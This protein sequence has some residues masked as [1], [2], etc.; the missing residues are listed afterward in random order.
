MLQVISLVFQ[1]VEG[2]ILDLPAGLSPPHDVPDVLRN[3]EKVGDPTEMLNP[4]IGVD[5][6]VFQHIDQFV[7]VRLVERHA[8]TEPKMMHNARRWI[9]QGKDLHLAGLTDRRPGWARLPW[10]ALWKP[11]AQVVPVM[12]FSSVQRSRRAWWGTNGW[13]A[14][15]SGKPAEVALDLAH[16]NPGTVGP[17]HEAESQG[18]NR[19]LQEE[20]FHG[21]V[22]LAD[23][24]PLLAGSAVKFQGPGAACHEHQFAHADLGVKAEL[25]SRAIIRA[26]DLDGEIGP[27]EPVGFAVLRRVARQE[28]R[29]VRAA[30]VTFPALRSTAHVA[31]REDLYVLPRAESGVDCAG[32]G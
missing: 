17:R 11:R 29:H 32:K 31:A 6:P 21:G 26:L 28:D 27:A 1:G 23:E 5:L 22:G 9:L 4:P 20:G 13:V 30:E 18:K 10:R 16:F 7:G 12:H 25:L 19:A 2:L 24:L 8:I 15:D 3:Q 14:D